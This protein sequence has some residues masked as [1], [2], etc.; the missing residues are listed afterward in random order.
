MSKTPSGARQHY[1]EE[2]VEQLKLIQ[3]KKP[4][5][6]N[7]FNVQGIQN[8]NLPY[9]GTAIGRVYTTNL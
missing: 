9:Q 6:S 8:S 1:K 2:L 7:V 3:I 4:L 5:P